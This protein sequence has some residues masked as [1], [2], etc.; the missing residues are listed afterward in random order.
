MVYP[1]EFKCCKKFTKN[2]ELYIIMEKFKTSKFSQP[3]SNF[4]PKSNNM[5]LTVK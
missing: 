5:F 2:T 4:S 3:I 1:S